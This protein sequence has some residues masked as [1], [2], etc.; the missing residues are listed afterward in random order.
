[1]VVVAGIVGHHDGD[2]QIKIAIKVLMS[3][4]DQGLSG[5]RR[6][7]AVDF[8]QKEGEVVSLCVARSFWRKTDIEEAAKR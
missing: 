3:L 2:E 1:M 4:G 5:K 7:T 8:L 6:S